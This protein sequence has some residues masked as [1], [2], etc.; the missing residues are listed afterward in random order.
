MIG[1]MTQSELQEVIAAME[2]YVIHEPR[3]KDFTQHVTAGLRYAAG[4]RQSPAARAIAAT[5]IWYRTNI[6][7][8]N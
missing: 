4:D 7:D 8:R 5:L 3:Q 1:K 2:H 6:K